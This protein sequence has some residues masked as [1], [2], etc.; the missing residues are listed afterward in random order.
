MHLEFL[1]LLR[2]LIALLDK[3]LRTFFVFDHAEVFDLDV[4][5]HAVHFGLQ[6]LQICPEFLNEVDK[7]L[8]R[9]EALFVQD[10]FSLLVDSGLALVQAL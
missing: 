5:W 10:V 2:K 9:L 1:D 7:L 4:A 3:L 8:I 6:L